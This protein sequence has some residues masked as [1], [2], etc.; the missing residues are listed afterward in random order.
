MVIHVPEDR[1]SM[2]R[3]TTQKLYHNDLVSVLITKMGIHIFSQVCVQLILS[4]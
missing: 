1:E 2:L 4:T 3:P